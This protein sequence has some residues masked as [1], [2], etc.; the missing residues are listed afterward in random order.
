MLDIFH[1]LAEVAVAITGFSSLII[2]FRGA[3]SGPAAMAP[4]P[5]RDRLS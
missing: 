5:V 4:R 3:A 2:I 1:T